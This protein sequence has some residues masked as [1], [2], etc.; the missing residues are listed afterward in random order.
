MLKN[1]YDTIIKRT[2]FIIAIVGLP[3]GLFIT[4]LYFISPTI[5]LLT[6][7]FALFLA[8]LTYLC[9]KNKK[10][11]T[12]VT[13]TSRPM[14]VFYDIGF[15]AAFSLSL[16][17]L[18]NSTERPVLYFALITFCAGLL[19]LSII[20]IECRTELVRQ[21]LKI[22]LISFNQILSIHYFTGGSGVDYWVHMEMNRLLSQIG[23]ISVLYGKESFYPLMHIHTAVNQIVMD[24]PIRDATGFGI[25]IP[26][27]ASSICVFLLGRSLFDEK[28]GL[29]AMLIVNISDFQI[30]YGVSPGT[31]SF[32][33]CLF[34]FFVYLVFKLIIIAKQRERI[35]W[36][37]LVF[38]FIPVL[39]LS[40]AHSSFVALLTLCAVVSGV[41]IYRKVFDIK[42]VLPIALIPII[43]VIE[44]LQHWFVAIYG[45]KGERSFFEV[46]L[47]TLEDAIVN[48]AGFLNRP[49]AATV[50]T[51]TGEYV[52]TLALP[53]FL[54]QVAD[55]MGLTLV[56]FFAIIGCL[57]WLS[58]SQRSTVKFSMVLGAAILLGFTFL[59]PLLGIRNI[60]PLR[61]F[62]F[63][64]FFLSLMTA[65]AVIK[66]SYRLSRPVYSKIFLFFIIS[67]LAF[68]M[69][70]SS[71]SNI[72]SPLWL[73]EWTPS[74][75]SY[76]IPEQQG[77]ITL[78]KYA[79]KMVSDDRYGGNHGS[80][81]GIQ[82]TSFSSRKDL[83]THESSI[84]L[85]REDY[86]DRPVTIQTNIEGYNKSISISTIL[87][88]E[89]LQ[90]LEKRHKMY[91]NSDLY[92][93]HLF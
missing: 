69:S 26:L 78:A 32:G 86:F 12:I 16:L 58:S 14:K 81:L 92:G 62:A 76:T 68:F 48:K 42:T 5:H 24:V 51:S 21:L 60:M 37:I 93:F 53:P 75:S 46:I 40:H 4:S 39:I 72:D 36:L 63:I 89:V 45:M 91:D 35:K 2:D 90:D 29:L 6:L 31:V 1:Y 73:K 82:V 47:Q 28:V 7:G 87:G 52:N 65:Y 50:E 20:S 84:F 79:D 55:V 57:F 15:F 61:W 9:I 80:Y 71:V 44:L 19:A 56:I 11:K 88:A 59:F 38:V 3:L 8:S 27:V 66:T 17:I 70:F 41:L 33:L 49:E 54:E 30:R 22:L 25:I 74:I 13:Y 83:N 64:Y 18:H 34:F 77:G 67:S 23:D 10:E 85:W 43:F